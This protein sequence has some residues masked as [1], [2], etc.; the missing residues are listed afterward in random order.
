M[1]T[2]LCRF[3]EESNIITEVDL[4]M[5]ICL[6]C[7]E[8]AISKYD[9]AGSKL[10]SSKTSLPQELKEYTIGFGKFR[11]KKILDVDINYIQWCLEN[12]NGLRDVEIFKTAYEALSGNKFISQIAASN[13]QDQNNLKRTKPQTPPKQQVEEDFPF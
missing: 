8:L 12:F 4:S 3:C 9:T 2:E 5:P 10:N 13:S 11:G 1:K 6:K 7:I